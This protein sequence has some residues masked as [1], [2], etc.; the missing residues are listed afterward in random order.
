MQGVLHSVFRRS[1]NIIHLAASLSVAVML[2]ALPLPRV[3]QAIDHFR[4][5]EIR[6]SIERNVFLERTTNDTSESLSSSHV[7]LTGLFL[8]NDEDRATFSTECTFIPQ[9]PLPRLLLRRNSG[10]S[11]SG[12]QDPL[13]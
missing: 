7:E 4:S 1:V 12:I 9:I 6:R 8:A 2:F 10:S 3:H 13:L 5:P 11:H